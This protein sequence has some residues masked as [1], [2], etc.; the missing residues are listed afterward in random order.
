MIADKTWSHNLFLCCDDCGLCCITA[1]LPCVTFGANAR[2]IEAG[3]KELISLFGANARQIE[4]GKKELILL[5]GANARQSEAGRQGRAGR[6]GLHL[7]TTKNS[8]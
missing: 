2:Q 1:L 6:Q 3:K 5:F 8:S 4:A 7:K